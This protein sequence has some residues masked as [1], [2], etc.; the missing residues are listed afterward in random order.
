MALLLALVGCPRGPAP[1]SAPIAELTER[2]AQRT[3]NQA[4]DNLELA[5][6]ALANDDPALAESALRVAVGIMGSPQADG[7]WA[8]LMGRESSKEW[9]GE[10]WERM[11]AHLQL[12]H[13]LYA[14]GDRGNAL[15]MYKS[16][17]LSDT[18]SSAE[19]FRSDLIAGWTL[20]GLVLQAEGEPDVATDLFR[21]A[22]DAVWS[23][24][25]VDELS[26]ALHDAEVAEQA[27]TQRATEALFA[28]I[29]AG[30]A[31]APRDPERAVDA[32]VSRA[33]E[34]MQRQR[35]LGPERR[36]VALQR[37]SKSDFELASTA[38]PALA[39]AW[40]ARLRA[41]QA[42]PL[43]S[44]LEALDT[45]RP[46]L[47]LVIER[48]QGPSKASEGAYGEK[49]RILPGRDG[50][51]PRVRIDNDAVDALFLDSASFQATTRGGRRVD[52]W[53][54]GKALYRD[55]SIISGYFLV[56]LSQELAWR[57]DRE[58]STL[59]AVAGATLMATGALTIPEADTR[60]WQ[61]IPESWYLVTATLPPGTHTISVD[62][63]RA[64]VLVP[65]SG[66]TMLFAPVR[67]SL[68]SR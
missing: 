41:P 67:G 7:E 58:G 17:V 50:R 35:S 16:A 2:A 65:Q 38:M 59:M 66:Q 42:P 25:V 9:K 3:R 5:T 55:T 60:A 28:A 11:A 68:V 47:V 10:P 21:R 31:A 48:G 52:G 53:L 46:N 29:P 23:R 44:S 34:L 14:K 22:A 19:R 36:R 20:Q 27:G 39:R 30:V 6:A 37:F 8:A 61:G 56:Y 26:E 12:G 62:G 15:A 18:G 45:A 33:V 32:T 63:E 43:A 54:Q 51:P 1:A 49:L 57:G 4:L 40:K 13:L 64:E 24:A